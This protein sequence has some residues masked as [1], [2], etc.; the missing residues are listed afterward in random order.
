[1]GGARP[2]AIDDTMIIVRIS[3]IGWLHRYLAPI[4]DD[5]RR[6]AFFTGHIDLANDIFRYTVSTRTV[7][8]IS[9]KSGLAGG[10]DA[11]NSSSAAPSISADGA[12]VAYTSFATNLATD[13]ANSTSDVFVT[14]VSLD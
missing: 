11:A 4:N 12:D 3:S 5:T 2:L 8:L 13:D 1:M 7:T 10:G 6:P 14:A 9:R